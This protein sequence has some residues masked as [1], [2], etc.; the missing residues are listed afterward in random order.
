[1]LRC[2]FFIKNNPYCKDE[3]R[4]V[5]QLISKWRHLASDLKSIV[6]LMIQRNSFFAY[7]KNLLISMNP[8]DRKHIREFRICR[9]SKARQY[10]QSSSTKQDLDNFV[11]PYSILP[12]K[13]KQK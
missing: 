6:D 9:K 7:P 13:I 8:Y 3:V 11:Y 1:M 5:F 12:V 4:H 2:V 10:P